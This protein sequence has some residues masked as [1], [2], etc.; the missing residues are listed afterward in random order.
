ME[1]IYARGL[2]YTKIASVNFPNLTFCGTVSFAR[3]PLTEICLPKCTGDFDSSF[4]ECRNLAKVDLP[5]A[6][7]IG[8]ACFGTCSVLRTLILRNT[9]L[10]SLVASNTTEWTNPF[11]GTPLING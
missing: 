7:I 6:E 8:A 2:E 1:K 3:T 9:S 11:S 5:A 10:C 4:I